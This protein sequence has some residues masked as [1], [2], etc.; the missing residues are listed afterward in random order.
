[1][2]AI[3]CLTRNLRLKKLSY[4]KYITIQ[5]EHQDVGAQQVVQCSFYYKHTPCAK[6]M[7]PY[8]AGSLSLEVNFISK[9]NPVSL[10]ND[11]IIE[12]GLVVGRY[13]AG[14]TQLV[15]NLSIS[16]LTITNHQ[17]KMNKTKLLVD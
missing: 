10:Q 14:N 5:P 6:T 15:I 8:T 4:C 13:G 16:K 7:W 11:L 1:M 12:C 3:L 17:S 2:V 9:Y